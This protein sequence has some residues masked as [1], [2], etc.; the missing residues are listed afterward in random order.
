MQE[1][2]TSLS[3]TERK[4]L[5]EVEKPY[6][7]LW[8]KY[9]DELLRGYKWLEDKGLI[10]LTKEEKEELILTKQGEEYKK[11]GLPEEILVKEL[12]T[13]TKKKSKLLKILTD[14]EINACI[15]ILKRLGAL[16]VSKEDELVFSLTKKV[17]INGW[18]DEKELVKR[19]ILET[20]KTTNY[21]AKL[22]SKGK[23]VL[24]LLSKDKT[25]YVEKVDSELLKRKDLTNIK[26]R[27]YDLNIK[28]PINERGKKHFVTEAIE[29]IK[30]IWLE[31]GFEEMTGNHVQSSFWNLDALFVPQDHPAR[32]MQDTFY[33]DFKSDLPKEAE[34]IKKAHEGKIIGKGWGYKYSNEIASQTLLRTHN[35]VLTA[36][37]LSKL[38]KEDL[39]K[40]YFSVGK[41]Y[42]NEALDWKHLFEFQQVEGFVVDENATL[43]SLK[44]YLKEFFIKMGYSDVRIRPAYFPYTEPS[45]EIDVFHP[46]KKEWVEIGG[47]GILRPE[48]TET[49]LGFKAK[50]LAFGLGM[51][52]IISSYYN[53]TDIREIYE[54]DLYKLKNK[55]IFIKR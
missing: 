32:E 3:N 22:T 43:L 53:I 21:I 18:K 20:K 35:T 19:G 52:R 14:Q 28:A 8:Q 55:K 23:Q 30:S 31:L 47:A 4:I 51:E 25:E 1:I 15:G 17:E 40:K 9:S 29:Y 44:N 41:V 7:E 33:L 36:I 38:K 5:P 54:N 45:A 42:R 39:P 26:F 27:S 10:T 48:V 34:Q 11:K 50:T 24:E 49:L 12:S 16:N 2:L 6:S 46:I 13:G 37:A